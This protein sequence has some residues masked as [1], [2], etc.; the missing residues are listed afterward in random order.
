MEYAFI[1]TLISIV[2]VAAALTIGTK[3]ASSLLAVTKGF[4]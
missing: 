1:G 2:I 4:E 3:T